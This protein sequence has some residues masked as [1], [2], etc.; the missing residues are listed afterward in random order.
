VIKN[1]RFQ[2]TAVLAILEPIPMSDC[3]AD[4]CA[5]V[6]PLA[7]LS[8]SAVMNRAEMRPLYISPNGDAWFLVRDPATGEAFVRHQANRR[9]GGQ[10]R[11][12]EIEAFLSG[13]R[14][15]EHEALLRLIGSFIYG[16]DGPKSGNNQSHES[17]S[18]GWSNAEL[19]ELGNMLWAGSRSRKS[20]AF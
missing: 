18:K 2:D 1:C 8:C 14:N 6:Q 9:S 20:R 3:G 13:P 11:D 12:T 17:T 5:R 16:R 7:L 19:T 10:V 15:P 4:V